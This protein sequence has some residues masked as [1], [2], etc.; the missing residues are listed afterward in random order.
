MLF[1]Q[2]IKDIGSVIGVIISTITLCGLCITPLRKSVI[3]KIKEWSNS[4]K[5]DE[6]IRKENEDIQELKKTLS[7]AIDKI[8][9]IGNDIK[10]LNSDIKELNV[11]VF[12]NE[13]DRLRGELFN[14]GNRCRRKIPLSLEEYRYIQTVGDKYLYKLHCNSIGEEEYHFIQEYFESEYN[15]DLINR[16]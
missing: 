6:A 11:R 9:D 4:D 1:I 5:Q 7:M 10:K 14:C 15:Q 8:S 3:K 13:K 16:N 2:T 12:D